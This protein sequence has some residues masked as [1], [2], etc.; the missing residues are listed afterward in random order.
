MGIQKEIAKA[1]T[2]I[3]LL[4]VTTII[5]IL[6]SLLFV[7]L[8]A[9]KERGRSTVCKN[10]LKQLSL[11]WTLYIDDN[12]DRLPGNGYSSCNGVSSSPMWVSGYLNPGAC[13]SDFKNIELLINPKYA[14]FANYIKQKQIYKCPSDT[15][16]FSHQVNE[17][18]RNAIKGQKVR[19]YSLNWNL[20]WNGSDSSMMSQNPNQNEVINK[21]G[22]IRGSPILFLDLY[23]ERLCWS[24]FGIKN[25]LFVMF[26]A[27]Y[28]GKAGNVSFTDGRVE[29]RKWRDP[30]TINYDGVQFHSHLH[31]SPQNKDLEWLYE[32]R[33]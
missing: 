10:N 9:V 23:S 13:G 2:L 4:T 14:Q 27:V 18:G 15:K 24:F 3:E 7:S 1:F 17:D 28:H 29:G 16:I 19:S 32:N 31:N 22:E 33:Y 25:D 11:T 6:A 30:R 12:D 5:G 26:P 8:S 21:A 20:G